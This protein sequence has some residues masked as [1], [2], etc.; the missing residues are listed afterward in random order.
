MIRKRTISI[1][2]ADVFFLRLVRVQTPE[3]Q[4]LS[5]FPDADFATCSLLAVSRALT[6]QVAPCAA[7]IDNLP[8]Q[9]QQSPTTVSPDVPLVELLN[10]SPVAS[11]LAPP[12]TPSRVGTAPTIY[13]NVNRVLARIATPAGVSAALTSHWWSS[14]FQ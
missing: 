9:A 5:L 4:G 7:L 13:S 6:V 14:A 2:A 12:A 10:A 1:D 11:G 8:D 3:D